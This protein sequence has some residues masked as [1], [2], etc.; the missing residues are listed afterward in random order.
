M[1]LFPVSPKTHT[2]NLMNELNQRN[3]WRFSIRGLLALA[4]LSQSP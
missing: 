2:A 1:T 3:G 4:L